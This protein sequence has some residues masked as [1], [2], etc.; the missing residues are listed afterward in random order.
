M[1][2]RPRYLLSALLLIG[3]SACASNGLNPAASPSLGGDPGVR[4]SSSI[5]P[6]E[7]PSRPEADFSVVIRTDRHAYLADPEANRFRPIGDPSAV[8][9]AVQVSPNGSLI[10]Y[11]EGNEA[12]QYR[13]AFVQRDGNPGKPL[14]TRT[15]W[16]SARDTAG[17][18]DLRWADD[19]TVLVGFM[20]NSYVWRYFAYE[21]VTGKAS[22]E[23]FYTRYGKENLAV[24]SPG[25][26]LSVSPDKLPGNRTQPPEI[27]KDGK[28][29]IYT[30][31]PGSTVGGLLID[32]PSHRV[33]A[34]LSS[35]KTHAWL[36][37]RYDPDS[38]DT[39]EFRSYS[40]P[41]PSGST[42]EAASFDF[43]ANSGF[44]L[45]A[46][47]DLVRELYAVQGLEN[48]K[49]QKWL[50]VDSSLKVVPAS[51]D[52]GMLRFEDPDGV[53]YE[54][55]NGRLSP[56]AASDSGLKERYLAKLREAYP[57][58]QATLTSPE[59]ILDIVSL[60]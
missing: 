41:L 27:L 9:G 53:L 52:S 33:A 21:P 2:T 34:A 48:P 17:I 45:V 22:Q 39:D 36:V 32:R 25:H 15:Q 54:P 35:D 60:P 5:L 10:A 28:Q 44:L 42:I 56:V 14:D 55:K 51:A 13:L 24:T 26:F 6:S 37:S 16:K 11:S 20:D 58:L 23:P 30:G 46:G 29:S 57:E 47:S 49:V 31:S 18:V 4:T 50:A 19:R 59:E 1:R 38:G 12:S 8:Q 40:L 43:A 7:G 3:L